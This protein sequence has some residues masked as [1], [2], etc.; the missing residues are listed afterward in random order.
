MYDSDSFGQLTRLV[1]FLE[2]RFYQQRVEIPGGTFAV[3]ENR[4]CAE[5]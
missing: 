4:P 3:N 2:R 5:I 1:S